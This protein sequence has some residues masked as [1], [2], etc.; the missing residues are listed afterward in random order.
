MFTRILS[1]LLVHKGNGCCCDLISN[2]G[3]NRSIDYIFEFVTDKSN[4]LD[5]ENSE[6]II[7]ANPPI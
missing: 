6:K 5:G 1:P 4:Q 2:R 7:N 3:C